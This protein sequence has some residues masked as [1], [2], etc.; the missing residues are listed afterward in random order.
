MICIVKFAYYAEN[1]WVPRI[2]I[3]G[4]YGPRAGCGSLVNSDERMEYC[5]IGEMEY[6][7]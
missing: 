4:R 2:S 6:A 5:R 1:D 3:R 7:G